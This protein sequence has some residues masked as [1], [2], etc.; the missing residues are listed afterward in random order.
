[1]SYSTIRAELPADEQAINALTVKAFAPMSFSDGSEAPII[2][3]L[4]R[5]GELSLS[6]VALAKE[7][8]IVGHVAFSPVTINGLHNEWFGLG[9]IS[10]DPAVQRAG[11]GRAL[12]QS[13]L[14][15]LRERGASGCALIGNPAIY[16]RYGFESDGLLT[17]GDLPADIVQRVVFAGP[18][19]TGDLKFASSFEVGNH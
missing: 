1:M 19:P 15:I 4:R 6:L 18:A 12:V 3:A 8:E 16:S 5:S 7:G 14:G 10:V 17:H 9:P 13:G 11:I 2:R